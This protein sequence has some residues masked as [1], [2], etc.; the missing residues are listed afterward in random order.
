MFLFQ[1]WRV[2]KKKIKKSV[3]RFF[4]FSIRKL[5]KG[6]S[7][8]FHITYLFAKQNQ[9]SMDTISVV[10][11][12]ETSFRIK[13]YPNYAFGSDKNLYNL[14]TGRMI[15]HTLNNRSKGYWIAG[16]FFSENKLRP[17]LIKNIKQSF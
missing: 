2:L 4:L 8:H 12:I 9:V 1:N 6:R 17:L 13:G 5:I 14:K 7:A 10:K 11:V 16:K 15:K 3:G